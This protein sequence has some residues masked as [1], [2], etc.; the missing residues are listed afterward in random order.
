MLPYCYSMGIKS[1]S[2]KEVA[3]SICDDVLA[4]QLKWNSIWFVI[5][6]TIVP[7]SV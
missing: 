3:A 5:P 7:N 2:A 4:S 1:N 6:V